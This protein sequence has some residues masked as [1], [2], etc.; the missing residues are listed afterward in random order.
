L[1]VT[2]NRTVKKGD[3]KKRRRKDS[4]GGC[5]VK[6]LSVVRKAPSFGKTRKGEGFEAREPRGEQRKMADRPLYHPRH[7]I[8]FGQSDPKIATEKT[9]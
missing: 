9:S 8:R 7:V 3:G 5:H 6:R 2:A 1:A 4:Q